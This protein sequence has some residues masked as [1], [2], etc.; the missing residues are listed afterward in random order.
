MTATRQPAQTIGDQPAPLLEQTIGANLEATAARFPDRPALISRHQDLRYTYAEFDAEVDRVAR[1][2][3]AAGLQK[4]D[5]LGVWSP[6]R[7][8]WALVQYATAKLGRDPRQ[9]QP[10]LPHARARLRAGAVRLPDARRGRRVQDQRLRR[11]ARRGPRAAARARAR[12]VLRDA[13]VGR[14]AR[15]RRRRG[16]GR[17]PRGAPRRSIPATRSTSSTRPGPRASPRARR[18]RTATSSTTASSSARAAA[19]ASR[20]GSASRSPTTTASA[21]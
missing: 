12:R 10:G 21:W 11:D 18:C 1:A 3:I 16:C 14:A 9:H 15:R 6:N 5:R 2:L 17:A 8:E 13:L 4:G 19:S 7:A 20:T